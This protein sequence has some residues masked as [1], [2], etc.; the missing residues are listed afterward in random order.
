MYF[1]LIYFIT[2]LQFTITCR[3]N[4][5][6]IVK[7]GDTAQDNTKRFPEVV[8][9][10]MFDL[11][12]DLQLVVWN[13][14]QNIFYAQRSTVIGNIKLSSSPCVNMKRL[15]TT[16]AKVLAVIWLTSL[17]GVSFPVPWLCV[18]FKKSSIIELKL[19]NLNVKAFSS[20]Q[21]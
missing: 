13:F 12:E 21:L 10:S 7:L 14:Q 5:E 2:Y 8:D 20:P 3:K 9:L 15:T 6:V 1:Q 4:N 18:Y 19:Y 16:V 11:L 17:I